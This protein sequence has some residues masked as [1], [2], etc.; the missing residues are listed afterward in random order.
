MKMKRRENR[1]SICNLALAAGVLVMAA[2]PGWCVAIPIANNSFESPSTGG[3]LG[4]CPTSWTCSNDVTLG[5]STIFGNPEFNPGVIPDGVQAV[6][7]GGQ[8]LNHSGDLFQALGATL[9]ADTTYTLTVFVG[10]SIGSTPDPYRASLEAAGGVILASDTTLNPPN[11][12]FLLDTITFNSGAS[13][14]QLGQ[15]LTVR[16]SGTGSTPNSTVWFDDVQLSATTT[17]SSSAPEPASIVLSGMALIAVGLLKRFR[18][19]A[20]R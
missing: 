8:N 10:H 2:T 7:I 9:Q 14:A 15:A 20:S 18:P 17:V 5:Q 16:L 12:S 1:L 11:D 13:P 4:G 19:R 3:S 6:L